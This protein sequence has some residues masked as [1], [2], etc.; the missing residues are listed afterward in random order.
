[1]NSGPTTAHATAARR[2]RRT[3]G[4]TAVTCLALGLGT[5]LLDWSPGVDAFA[6]VLYVVL[7]GALVML[8]RPV[9]PSL[10][11]A[12]IAFGFATTMELLQLTG[13]AAAIV[14]VF[15][16]A[17]LVFGNAFDPFDIVAYAGGAIVVFVLRHLA[18]GRRGA[19]SAQ[20]TA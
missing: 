2:I 3:A 16:L 1:M 9:M 7:V 12:S 13:V 17:H 14:E 6:S 5:Q 8:I 10:V 4:V 11:I 15:P 19:A 18:P 20:S